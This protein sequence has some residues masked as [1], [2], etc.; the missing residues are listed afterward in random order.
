M[1][2]HIVGI[3]RIPQNVPEA[4]AVAESFINKFG[5]EQFKQM[6]GFDIKE[7]RAWEEKHRKHL[8][9]W[10]ECMHKYEKYKV[11]LKTIEKIMN[12]DKVSS[13]WNEFEH[14]FASAEVADSNMIPTST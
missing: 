10:K 14:A 4:K 2:E 13:V 6:T 11:Y 1:M 8:D 12:N 9:K 5:E 7:V 3:P